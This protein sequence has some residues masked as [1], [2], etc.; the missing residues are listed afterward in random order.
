[1]AGRCWLRIGLWQYLG[2]ALV[3]PSLLR[4]GYP[5]SGLEGKAARGQP[6]QGLFEG[7]AEARAVCGDSPKDNPKPTLT[8]A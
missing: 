1:M 3:P 2:S 6:L 4:S 5:C 8:E 7:E